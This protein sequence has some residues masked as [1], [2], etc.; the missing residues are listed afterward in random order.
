MKVEIMAAHTPEIDT[1]EKDPSKL[2]QDNGMYVFMGEV[3]EDTIKPIIEWILVE[4]HVAK[5]KKKELLLMICS[6][7]GS[8]ENAFALIDVMKSSSIPVKTVGLGSIASSGLLI[9]LAGT[10]G[11]RVLTPNTSILSHQYSWGSDGKHHELWAVTKEFG[12]AH[13]RMVRHY[14]ESTGLDEETIKTKLLP[15]NDVYLS[16]EEALA[17]GICDYISDLKK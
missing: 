16:A 7:G 9:F 5:K 17:L 6:D 15:A 1:S 3:A 11:R 12:L 2:L 4:N 10:K 8:M 14:Q 13:Q